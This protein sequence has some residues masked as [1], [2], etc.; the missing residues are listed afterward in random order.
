M[1]GKTGL[2][3]RE[4]TEGRALGESTAHKR[5]ETQRQRGRP[6]GAKNKAKSLIPKELADEILLKLQP[7]VP[8][9]HYD[10]MRGVIKEGK[11]VAV[12]QEIDTI[13]LLLSR[14]LVPALI[15]E[16]EGAPSLPQLEGVEGEPEDT[17]AIKMPMFNKD[18]TD[19]LKVLKEFID[20]KLRHERARD[21]SDDTSKKPIIEVF[22]RRG[23]D[24]DRLR[25]A[26]EH[27]TGGVGGSPD[28]PEGGADSTRELPVELSKRPLV[29]EGRGESEADRVLDGSGN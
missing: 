11:A 17:S 18:V 7:L 27:V 24:A 4:G 28:Q 14:Q 2:A 5:V 23:L 15:K 13:L 20:M 19:R 25:I 22:A 29:L 9:E 16:T 6:R 10:Y 3:H 8:P 12:E 21:D 1:A 26:I